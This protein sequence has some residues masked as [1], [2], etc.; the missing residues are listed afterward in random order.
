MRFESSNLASNESF[1]NFLYDTFVRSFDSHDWITEELEALNLNLFDLTEEQRKYFYSVYESMVET[2][3]KNIKISSGKRKF[4]PDEVYYHKRFGW[5]LTNN[6]NSNTANEIKIFLGKTSILGGTKIIMGRRTYIS[7]HSLIKGGGKFI[8]GSFSS[9]AEGFKVF[10]SSDSHPMNHAAMVNLKGNSR[11]VEDGFNMEIQYHEIDN[12]NNKVTIGSDVWVGRN[13]SI[14]SG[15]KI[16][17]GCVIGEG[18]LVRKD[19]KPYGVYAGYPAKL[20]RFR[21]SEQVIEQLLDIEWWNWPIKKIINNV[22]FFNTDLNLYKRNLQ[23]LIIE[24]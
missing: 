7:G 3:S 23:D 9:L 13:V 4:K 14:K 18:S 12:L 15:V 20:I 22:I 1:E 17:N 16:G 5:V 8:V 2:L 21:F 6:S 10:T 19:C 24:R 11:M